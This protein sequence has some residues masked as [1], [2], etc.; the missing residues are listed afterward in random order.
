MTS[1]ASSAPM[2]SSTSTPPSRRRARPAPETRGSGILDRH[3]GAPYARVEQGLGAGPRLAPMAAR[4]EGDVGR[5]APGRR[6]GARQR[7]RL[8][9][10][11]A[12]GHGP[13]PAHDPPG[14][15]P[16]RD[17]D[18]AHRRVGPNVAEAAPGE[19]ERRAHMAR[20]VAINLARHRPTR[21]R[22]PRNPWPRG[23][24]CKPTRSAHRPP[25]RARAARPSPSRRWRWWGSRSRPSFRGAARCR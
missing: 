24:S 2:P 22:T 9:M 12:A 11:P 8:G 20:I 13:S 16:R 19:A 21:P 23:N 6:P 25:G 7:L 4:L 5:G 17:Q 18:T 15:R 10:G 1:A 14:A 3:H